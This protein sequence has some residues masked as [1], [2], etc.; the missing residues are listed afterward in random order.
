MTTR[1]FSPFA[2]RV[3]K[4]LVESGQRVSKGDPLAQIESADYGQA[5]ADAAKASSDFTLAERNL[6]RVQQLF[7]HGAA[8]AKDLASAEADVARWRSDRDRTSARL[9]LYGDTNNVIDQHYTL[10]SPIDGF[11][12]EKSVNPGQEVRPDQM[13]AGTPQLAA[14]LF[15]ITDP[16]QLWVWMDAS[17]MDLGQIKS[18]TKCSL[19]AAP[20]PDQ[21]FTGM[22]DFIADSLDPSS[23]TVKVR[24]IVGNGDRH[25]KSEMLVTIEVPTLQ[26]GA[27]EISSQAVF[28]Q[29]D[30]NFVVVQESNGKFARRP[31]KIGRRLLGRVLVMTGL[32]SSDQVVS[33]GAMLIAQTLNDDAQL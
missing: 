31:V 20:Y 7:E 9:A 29:G 2:G 13:L 18:G 5:Q 4:I 10:R 25:L 8:P 24:G 16:T 33:E 11:V 32:K 26:K 27:L 6:L 28:L 12:V 22:I 23:R 14:P 21:T 30:G 3:A 19:H 17:E 1:L 15:V